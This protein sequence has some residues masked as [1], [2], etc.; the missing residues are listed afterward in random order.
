M[1]YCRSD[2]FWK[3][4]CTLGKFE[5]ILST[6]V[7]WPQN[8]SKK[9]VSTMNNLTFYISFYLFT[10]H[11]KW[12]NGNSKPVH[13]SFTAFVQ[14]V[15]KSLF[16]TY[17]SSFVV[18]LFILNSPILDNSQFCQ[19]KLLSLFSSQTF[20]NISNL[21]CSKFVVTNGYKVSYWPYLE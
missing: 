13:S 1:F 11:I 21:K 5:Y 10:C 7:S 20:S 3:Y 15:S 9:M 16:N 12:E 8:N 2:M 14:G 4:D 18:F 17:K 19:S 6:I